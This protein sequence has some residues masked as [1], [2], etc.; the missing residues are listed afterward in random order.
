MGRTEFDTNDKDVIAAIQGA[1][2]TEIIELDD[3]AFVTRP[4]HMPPAPPRVE[5]LTT[6]TLQSVIDYLAADA[7]FDAVI[8][9]TKDELGLAVHIVSPIKVQI[10]GGIE[11]RFR[12]REVF[13]NAE[14]IEVIGETFRFGRFYPLE[15]FIISLRSLFAETEDRET[16]IKI[17][18][19]VEDADVK[20]FEDDGL[21]QSVTA[22]VGIAT[23]AEVAV[24]AVVMLAPWRSFPEISQPFSDFF[25]RLA[26]GVDDSPAAALFETDGGKWKIEAINSIKEFLNKKVGGVP[27]I[28]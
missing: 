24:P 26:P 12:T 18:G 15:Q 21:S 22:R 16:V 27:I 4:V 11:G 20:Q 9:T 5:P 17:L 19:R 13:I 10:L 14:A 7:K 6:H 28:A 23:K 2:Q 25:L 3:R 1:V 8:P